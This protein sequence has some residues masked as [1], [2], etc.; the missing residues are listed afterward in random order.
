MTT[1]EPRHSRASLLDIHERAHRSLRGLLA[2]CAGLATADLDRELAGFGYPTVRLQLHHV[3][4][5]EKYWV[6]VLLGE[7]HVEDDSAD[8]PSIP[9]LDIHERRV[10]DRTADWLRTT[11]LEELNTPRL[12][13][14]WPD[15]KRR[16]VPAHVILRTQTHIYHHQGQVLAMCRL[17]GRPGPGGL[18][19]PLVDA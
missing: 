9:A 10:A 12:V 13:R 4:S 11:S 15:V 3:I 14:T 18:D 2:H 6:G 8:Y 17:L 5:A 7:Y 19:F 16:L 1:N